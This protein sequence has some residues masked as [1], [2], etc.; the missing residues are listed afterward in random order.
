MLLQF[1]IIRKQYP[2]NVGERIETKIQKNANRPFFTVKRINAIEEEFGIGYKCNHCGISRNNIVVLCEC[3]GCTR[4]WYFQYCSRRCQKKD[5]S[6]HRLTCC[7]NSSWRTEPYLIDSDLY[8][9]WKG[10]HTEDANSSRVTI[11]EL[12]GGL[13]CLG[14]DPVTD[15]L[16]DCFTDRP[17]QN[18][19]E[20]RREPD[21]TEGSR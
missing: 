16:F 12:N 1:I 14:V 7:K 6:Q 2:P 8:H 5:W 13:I 19:E 20:K 4:T 10:G 17:V 18:Y 15:K 9:N 11:R 21:W 3:I